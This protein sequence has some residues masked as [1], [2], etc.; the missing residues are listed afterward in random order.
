MKCTNCGKEIEDWRAECPYCKMNFEKNKQSSS[1][2]KYL[3]I[4][5]NINL[6]ACIVSALI[7]IIPTLLDISK[8]INEYEI[9]EEFT[10]LPIGY[11]IRLLLVG[12]TTFFLLKT[13]ADIYNK[14][15][16]K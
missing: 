3:N 11:A 9:E 12:F 8:D 2:A 7:L 5:A 6:G 4:M 14:V 10:W 13:I 16:K 15:S 1:N